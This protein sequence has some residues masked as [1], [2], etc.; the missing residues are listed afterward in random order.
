[1]KHTLILI[2]AMLLASLASLNAAD[3]K[4]AKPN[5]VVILIDD[6][7]YGDIGP[8]GSKVNRT[9]NLDRMAKEGMKLTSFY[10]A[11]VCTASRAQLMTGCYAKR[12]GLDGALRP[13]SAS[14]LNPSE[15]TVAA[16]LKQSGYATMCIGKWH[17]GDQLP[18]MPLAHGFD[19]FIGLP[20]SN[21]EGGKGK[22]PA[23]GVYTSTGQFMPPL[24]YIRDRK[25]EEAPVD[26]TL[27]EDRYT[28]EAVKFIGAN[29]EHPFFLYLPHTAVHV[30]LNPG[31]NFAG[32]S[33]NGAFGDW[34]EEVDWSVGQVLDTLRRL[35]L[36]KNTLV[37]FTSDNGPWLAFGKEG[38]TGGPLRGGKFSQWEGGSREPII[39]WWPG[40]IAPGTSCDT[41]ASEM[42]V[43][44]TFVKLAGG[45]VSK[46]R[47]IDGKDIWPLLS[48][49]NKTSPH[50][51]LYYWAGME[52]GAVRSGEWK[53]LLREQK[54]I[55]VHG[56]K[57]KGE[58][59]DK[60]DKNQKPDRN[61]TP[62]LFN[63]SQDIGE[64]TDVAA[65]H[66]GV[67]KR[68]MEFVAEMAPDLG[69]RGNKALGI[70]PAG[71]VDHPKPLLLREGREYD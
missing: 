25:I 69:V 36:D 18:F 29:K 55:E 65:A 12:V 60:R 15:K 46:E 70:R 56:Q 47:K 67:V 43:L 4:P 32:K 38:G 64:T 50:E 28:K 13:I 54:V 53:L 33:A 27:L 21:D 45:E 9:P 42:D 16:L 6:M 51:S 44:P 3:P 19:H 8:F 23:D 39:A 31:K 57:P 5:F 26:Q 52:L 20:Y 1:M 30:P 34:V 17:L 68:L 66:P 48:G 71:H 62:Q 22:A 41:I 63:L 61:F 11:P 37:I 49:Q 35:Q 40:K 58:K 7:G 24:P 10:C 14:G 2:T 59:K